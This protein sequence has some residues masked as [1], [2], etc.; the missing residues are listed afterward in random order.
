MVAI[1]V[2]AVPRGPQL[3]DSQLDS[4]VE[5]NVDGVEARLRAEVLVCPGCA[6][7][8]ASGV[9]LGAARSV[10][11]RVG[12]G[13][14]RRRYRC[15]GCDVTHVLLPVLV[16]ARRADVAAQRS[17]RRTNVKRRRMYWVKLGRAHP[18]RSAPY[19]RR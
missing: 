3:L 14:F 4:P 15:T 7:V 18:T 6:E 16:P 19:R 5:A 11:W 2:L 13:S 10:A 9:G 8:L 1:W 12:C 17:D